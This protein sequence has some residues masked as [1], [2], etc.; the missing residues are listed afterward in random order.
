MKDTYGYINSTMGADG[1]QVDVFLNRKASKDELDVRDVF[2]VSQN[3]VSTGEFDEHKVIFG[4]INMR[5]AKEIYHRN[6][7]KN[8]KGFGSAKRMVLDSFKKWIDELSKKQKA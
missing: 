3:N 7:A 5:D 8:Y 1:D 2:V 6:Y 4:A